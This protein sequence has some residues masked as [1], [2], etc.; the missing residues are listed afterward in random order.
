MEKAGEIWP[1]DQI[2]TVQA[3]AANRR[4]T[5]DIRGQVQQQAGQRWRN[6]EGKNLEQKEQN[7]TENQASDNKKKG[8][9]NTCHSTEGE[10]S[11][12][13]KTLQFKKQ[14]LKTPYTWP[15]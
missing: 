6:K 10:N 1:D 11:H 2:H 5:V 15:A 14:I 4:S 12:L 13:Q 3:S 8:D 7:T 9:K